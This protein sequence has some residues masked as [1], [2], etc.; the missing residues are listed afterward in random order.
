MKAQERFLLANTLFEQMI[1]PL[2]K[3]YGITL[4][5]YYILCFLLEYPNQNT[6]ADIVKM[7]N[8]TKSHVSISVH[9]LQEKG[10]LIGEYQDGNRKTIRLKMTE[11]AM[12][13]T[14]QARSIKDDFL[15]IL[16]AGFDNDDMDTFRNYIY[17]IE[18]N[19]S[20]HLHS[21]TSK[22]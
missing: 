1:S 20:A 3:Q 14:K 19:I 6:A 15:Q 2:R 4:M 10:F 7:R 21:H 12:Q 9:S 17:R 16:F 22:T 8:F 11:Q 18:E 13:F 5:E